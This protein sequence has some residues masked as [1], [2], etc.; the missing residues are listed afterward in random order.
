MQVD[1][2]VDATEQRGTT[3]GP[4]SRNAH[5]ADQGGVEDG[6]DGLPVV[7]GPF[8]ETAHPGAGRD[9]IRPAHVRSTKSV[10]L[11]WPIL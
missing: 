7:V 1:G 5:V 9:P 2:V 8:G 6:V 3:S 11:D 10:W 4:S